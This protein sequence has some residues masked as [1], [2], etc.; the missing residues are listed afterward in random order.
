LYIHEGIGHSEAMAANSDTNVVAYGNNPYGVISLP[1]NSGGQSEPL[2][3][4]PSKGGRLAPTLRPEEPNATA[5][6]AAFITAVAGA[7]NGV[8][9]DPITCE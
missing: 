1:G 3:A 7:A 6:L 8:L 4:F 2:H 9:T 5:G